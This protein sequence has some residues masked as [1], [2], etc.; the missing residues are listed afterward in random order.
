MPQS[1]W[2]L[3]PKPPFSYLLFDSSVQ[4][5]KSQG[6]II[7]DQVRALITTIQP[8]KSSSSEGDFMLIKLSFDAKRGLAVAPQVVI[9][10]TKVPYSG[11]A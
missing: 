6:T 7:E 3:R 5:T 1:P 4:V 8:W 9:D 10:A 2:V 11:Q